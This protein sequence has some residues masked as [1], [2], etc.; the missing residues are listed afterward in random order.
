VQNL[1]SI[2]HTLL[3]DFLDFYAFYASRLGGGDREFKVF[4][5]ERLA[6]LCVI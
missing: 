6:A 5:V 4:V 1:F 2:L 3:A